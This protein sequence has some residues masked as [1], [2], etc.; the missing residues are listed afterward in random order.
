MTT[1]PLHIT[2]TTAR[3]FILGRQGL[4]PGRR[5]SG[6]SGAASAIQQMEALQLDP[7]NVCGRSH[8][9]ALYGRVLQFSPELLDQVVYQERGFFD[10]GGCL[11]LYPMAELPYWRLPMRRRAESQR[12]QDFMIKHPNADD[13]VRQELRQRGPLGNRDLSGSVR[14]DSYRGR[15]DSALALFY[16][17]LAG[18]LMVHHRRRFERIYDFRHNIAPARF[19]TCAPDDQAEA[20][21]AR[22]AVAF[23]GLARRRTWATTM[24]DYLQE[25]LPAEQASTW[26]DQLLADGV[27]APVHVEGWKDPAC[28][29]LKQDLALLEIIASGSYPLEWQPLQ[30]STSDEVTLLAPL[31]IASARG[32]AQQL[33]G[34]EYLWEVYK[35]VHQRRW[36]YYTLPV[37]YRDRLVARLDPRLERSQK[38]LHILGFWLEEHAPTNDPAFAVALGRGLA[39]FATFLNAE[40]VAI[41]AL[42]PP[43]LQDEVAQ[44]LAAHGLY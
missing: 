42:H 17:W 10:Y 35:P 5:W 19:D 14:V 20:F 27:Y 29:A 30:A 4:W 43:G 26:L 40:S 25:R 9:I 38:R 39:R 12:L 37:L 2:A 34:F 6:A 23:L 28:L 31:E 33:F 16:L 21:F 1:S 32:R 44:V 24:S 13:A 41:D 11:F 8:E 18:E 7:L 3:R 15:K 22:K 36:G